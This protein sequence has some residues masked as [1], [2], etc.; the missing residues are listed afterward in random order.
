MLTIYHNPMCK[1]SRACLDFIKEKNIEYKI[2]NYFKEPISEKEFR[3]LMIRLNMKPFDM[4]R[5][6]EALYKNSFKNSQFN[7]DEWIKI[8]LEHPNLIMRPVVSG[9][10][11]A[12]IGDPPQNILELL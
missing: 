9:I 11:K 12:V 1:K 5:K 7:D 6:Q 4:V 3:K 10:Y 8:L 2:V